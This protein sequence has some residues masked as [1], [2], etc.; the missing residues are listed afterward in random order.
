MA[1]ITVKQ[2]RGLIHRPESQR[3]IVLALGLGRIG[4]TREI[5]DTP[6]VRGMVAKVAHLVE[7]VE[8]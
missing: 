7:I 4:K 2:I 3:K 1:T 8:K 6:A 5:N